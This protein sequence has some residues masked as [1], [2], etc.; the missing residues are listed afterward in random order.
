[1]AQLDVLAETCPGY[2]LDALVPHLFGRGGFGPDRTDYY[3]P[4]NSLIN[5]VLERRLGIPITLSVVALE[6]GRRH[7]R[8][9]GGR[10]HAG[11]LP[12][13][14]QGR[15][16]GLHRPFPRRPAARRRR[17]ASGS[18]TSCRGPETS[19]SADYLSP[20]GNLSIVARMLNNLRVTYGQ[21][22]DYG[23]LRWVLR[24]AGGAP[25]ALRRRP[26][27]RGPGDGPHE[28][29]LRRRSPLRFDRLLLAALGNAVGPAAVRRPC[30]GWTHRVRH[31][32]RFASIGSYSLRSAMR[33]ATRRCARQCTGWTLRVRQPPLR[34]DR[35]LLAALGN[36][37]GHAAVRSAVHWLDA[38][39]PAASASLRSAPTRCARQCVGPRAGAAR[40]CTGWTH[41]SRHALQPPASSRHRVLARASRPPPDCLLGS[42]LA[43]LRIRSFGAC[44]GRR[45]A[46]RG[47]TE[48]G[49]WRAAH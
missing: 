31:A 22:H 9:H 45:A 44:F 30:T 6:V 19:W 10:G 18:S 12:P 3:D 43:E 20:V 1:M 15:P 35:L 5:H 7:R 41:R 26:R 28:L 21:R 49:G 42:L 17:V 16:L 46:R 25:A 23:G 32:V 48:A 11:A 27:R 33:R 40:P 36:A 39:G 37:S 24:P 34:F 2:T 8:A 14:G 38:P 4:R 29:T 47:V 13:P